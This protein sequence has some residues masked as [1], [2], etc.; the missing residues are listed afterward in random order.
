[1]GLVPVVEAD[2]L[3]R[4]I[5]YVTTTA[6]TWSLLVMRGCA[7]TEHDMVHIMYRNAAGHSLNY[8]I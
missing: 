6:F 3:E 4:V 5:T 8:G 7:R 2:L 1:M